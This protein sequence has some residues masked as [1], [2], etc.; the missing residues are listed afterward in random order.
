MDHGGRMGVGASAHT[1]SSLWPLPHFPQQTLSLPP[2]FPHFHPTPLTSLPALAS[3]RQTSTPSITHQVSR[4]YFLVPSLHVFLRGGHGTSSGQSGVS[5]NST[6]PCQG[7]RA[8][9]WVLWA[10]LRGLSCTPNPS[11]RHSLCMEVTW[12]LLL[13]MRIRG[14]MGRGD[15]LLNPARAS[16]FHFALNLT[17]YV[18]GLVL[19]EKY[20]YIL[21][22]RNKC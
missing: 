18:A 14:S 15:C 17:N 13:A 11:T 1:W 7:L 22:L 6:H 9:Q 12:A 10:I 16:H 8:P 2:Q 19:K 21:I 3:C 5:L 20:M 4:P